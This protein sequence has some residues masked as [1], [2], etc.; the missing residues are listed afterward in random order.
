MNTP[1]QLLVLCA[2]AG[3]CSVAPENAAPQAQPPAAAVGLYAMTAP[4]I[5]GVAQDLSQYRGRVALVVN[6]ASKCG[7]TP[8]Y[9][10][11]QKLYAELGPSGLV[12]L[13]FPSNDFGAQEPGTAEDIKTFCNANYGV[14]FPLFAKVVTKAG[15][16][17]SPVYDYLGSAAGS[18]PNWNFCKYL[19]GKDGK[20]LA[21]Y[22]SKVTPESAELR[23][24]IAAALAAR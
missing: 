18:L 24:A 19:V 17:Q 5:D 6:T 21:F 1:F 13:G 11:L 3:G 7:Y 20:V 22:P 15:A 16:G 8:Q 4:N 2:L 10:G 9:D 14:S 23:T 12:I